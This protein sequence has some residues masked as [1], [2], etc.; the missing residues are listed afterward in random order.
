MNK[1]SPRVLVI[2]LV[3][4]IF[5]L[6]ILTGFIYLSWGVSKEYFEY[7]TASHIAIKQYPIE[8][9]MT[10][11]MVVCFAIS[12]D[13]SGVPAEIDKLFT[14]VENYLGDRNDSWTVEVVD[15]KLDPNEY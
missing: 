6:T 4:I 12:R 10:P 7:R 14:G 1:M 9:V 15:V 11:S 5:L 13:H 2:R 8:G 3:W